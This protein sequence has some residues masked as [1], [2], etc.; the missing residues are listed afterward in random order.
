[1]AIQNR[2]KPE[3]SDNSKYAWSFSS[4]YVSSSGSNSDQPVARQV[5]GIRAGPGFLLAGGSDHG[6]CSN[7]RAWTLHQSRRHAKCRRSTAVTWILPGCEH[8]SDSHFGPGVVM[9]CKIKTHGL[10]SPCYGGTTNTTNPRP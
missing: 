1:M 9:S 5:T 3:T 7:S 8:P 4:S 6:L 10:G 2:R